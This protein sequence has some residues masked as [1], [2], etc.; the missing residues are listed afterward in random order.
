MSEI[1]TLVLPD[2]RAQSA[3][4]VAE[5]THRSM[6]DILV[7]W[8][9][10]LVIELPLDTLPDDQVLALRDLQMPGAEQEE[11]SALLA[12][13]RE[14]VL[15]ATERARLDA[16]MTIYRQGM[17]RKAQATKIAVERGLQPPL[18]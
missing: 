9:D 11:L 10:R 8:L 12:M 3:R 18:G 13:Q 15:A 6:E 16:L 2:S 4:V 5:R 1:V 17:V 14:R 7:D